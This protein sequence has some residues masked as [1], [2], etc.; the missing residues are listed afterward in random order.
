METVGTLRRT[1]HPQVQKVEFLILG[2]RSFVGRI[3]AFG[4]SYV[5]DKIKRPTV[6]ADLYFIYSY[7]VTYLLTT[8]V[9]LV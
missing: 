4:R 2:R 9:I 8:F 6:L 1:Q 3:L 7:F 5:C